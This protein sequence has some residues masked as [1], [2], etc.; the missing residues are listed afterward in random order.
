MAKCVQEEQVKDQHWRTEQIQG[1]TWIL[2]DNILFW[3]DQWPVTSDQW[4]VTSDQ[5]AV[6]IDLCS[7]HDLKFSPDAV[8]YGLYLCVPYVSH[9]KQRLFPQI[10]LTGWAL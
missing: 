5:W 7:G 10:P 1:K 3:S 4:P 8:R 9:S 2:T 6:I